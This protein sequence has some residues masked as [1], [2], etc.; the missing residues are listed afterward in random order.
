MIE[1]IIMQAKIRLI[2][3]I[4]G[5]LNITLNKHTLYGFTYYIIYVL[6]SHF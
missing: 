2:L 5:M 1:L 6:F 3:P 4:L